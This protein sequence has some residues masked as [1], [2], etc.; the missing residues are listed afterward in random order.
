MEQQNIIN[1]LDRIEKALKYIQE[2]MIDTDIIITEEEKRMLNES[3]EHEKS[4]DLV[5]LEAIKK[6]PK[7]SL[8]Q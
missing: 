3:V 1:R 4:G 7:I 8:S 6:L 5:S 2:N